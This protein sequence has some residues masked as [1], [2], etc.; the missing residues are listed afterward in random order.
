[1]PSC[2][3]AWRAILL[4]KAT[5]VEKSKYTLPAFTAQVEGRRFEASMWKIFEKFLD[6]PVNK[7]KYL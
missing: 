1:M 3:P 5:P 6:V 4:A 2:Y 7:D